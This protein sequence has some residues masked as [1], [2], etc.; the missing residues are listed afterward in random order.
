M[1]SYASYVFDMD[2]VLLRSNG[3]K[4]DA[5]FRAALPYGEEMAREMVRYHQQAG[6]VSRK[7]RWEHFF[8][9]IL[10]REPEEG[11][12]ER[13]LASCS[14]LVSEG[15]K[16]A[17]KM[18]GVESYLASLIGQNVICVTGVLTAEA[19]AILESHA[20]E[21]YFHRI[22]GG[23]RRKSEVLKRLIG[24]GVIDMPAVYFGDTEDDYESAH[25]NG[26]DF[27]FVSGDT[28]FDGWEMF[29]VDKAITVVQS[30][31][32]LAGVAINGPVKVRVGRDG[33]ASV[34]GEL[35]YVGASMAGSEV[36]FA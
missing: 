36:T 14:E 32:D 28:E 30:L 15:M 22:Y 33:T 20:L 16:S 3:V 29:A 10:G 8:S 9:D 24:A 25:A 31:E 17:E 2:G 6:S 19:E 1:R 11:E 26:L 23:P 7:E 4:S 13:V 5:F 34:R 21:K 12:L 18:P 27:V 35:V